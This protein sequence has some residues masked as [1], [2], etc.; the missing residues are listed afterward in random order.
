MSDAV[1][2][3]CLM[4]AASEIKQQD[5]RS[6]ARWFDVVGPNGFASAI[7][8]LRDSADRLEQR[9]SSVSNS[10]TETQSELPSKYQE[11]VSKVEQ[12]LLVEAG[13]SKSA[14]ASLMSQEFLKEERRQSVPESQRVA[15]GTWLKRLIDQT[16]P[17]E[18]L[19][20]ATKLR[21]ELLHNVG[22]RPDWS[23][24]RDVK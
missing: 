24:K 13:L 7:Q 1:S 11:I 5:I 14:A 17:S 21:N 18:T 8:H 6:F 2:R 12:L 15:F 22:S 9:Y 20:V 16:S 3:I 23:L 19:H 4:L 10:K